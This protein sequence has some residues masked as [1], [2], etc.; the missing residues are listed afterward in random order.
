MSRRR[1]QGLS[2]SLFPFLAVLVCTLGTLILLLALV[3]Q[4]ATE[5]A[6]Q[7]ARAQSRV[8]EAKLKA[9]E[10]LPAIP[11]MTA[12]AAES[13]I[14]EQR[15][16]VEQLIAFRDKQT[17]DLEQRRDQLTHM[18]DH[19]ERLR[20]KL[21]RLS[22]EVDNAMGETSVPEIDD[23]IVAKLHASIDAERAAIEQIRSDSANKTP[24]VV[25]V[26]HK[27]PN[28]TDRRPVY[29]ECDAQGVTIWPEGSRITVAQLEDSTP[30]ANP[31]DAA[32]RAVRYHT[33]Q[34]YGDTTP[35][36]P[37]LV[38]RPD[39]IETYGAARKAMLDWDDQFGYELVPAEVKLAF[40]KP[41]SNL[42]QRVEIAI[43][44]AAARQYA[45]SAIVRR[46]T[47]GSGTGGSTHRSGGRMPTLSAA[48][49]D[50]AGRASGF[51]SAADDYRA[52]SS[53]LGRSPYTRSPP[54]TAG[55]RYASQND[56]YS[57]AG[58]YNG[59]YANMDPSASTRELADQMRNAAK[60]MREQQASSTGQSGL[61][62]DSSGGE[63]DAEN[64]RPWGSDQNKKAQD[65]TA[66]NGMAQAASN[67]N[68]GQSREELNGESSLTAEQS[69]GSQSDTQT[70]AAS[71]Q[72]HSLQA[73]SQ[74]GTSQQSASQ[75]AAGSGGPNPSG[76][77]SS[78][79]TTSQTDPHN[80][81]T[82]QQQT[83]A[84]PAQVS[85]NA[86]PRSDLVRRQGRDWALP[87]NMAG[88]RGNSIVRTI[89]VQC[90][91]DR[92]VL[93]PPSTGG[94]TEMFGFSDGDLDRATLELATAVRD[95]IDRWG[96][97]LPGGRWQPRLEVQVAPG[98][99]SR[100]HQLR[101][102][103][104]GSGVEVTGRASP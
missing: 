11:R 62:G 59:S 40:A 82:E 37:L 55:S 68:E 88:M 7:N 104:S 65:T 41:D 77:H 49:L 79:L 1:R 19:L 28:G 51:R 66:S 101:S 46:A 69:G 70:Q 83:A 85:L 102:L 21:K 24:R 61:G 74:S 3:A 18:E 42:K 14:S 4:N 91:S 71:P 38:V 63:Q 52:G 43:R 34:N 76:T 9:A 17:A 20:Q 36:Y 58:A 48:T 54:P 44:E 64:D 15:F 2:P 60:E 29:L 67:P 98:G 31:L 81:S 33:M 97:S 39:G 75:H 90:Y 6:E 50:R 56:A 5:T 95:R 84:V 27:G 80:R 30:S 57:S 87:P 93:L 10:A 45:R 35:P 53:Q 32:L 26:P 13:M 47:R 94:A 72:A 99:E 96:A 8:A 16:R 103:M 25:I 89:R 12:K 100:F 86:T 92:L 73:P 22:D 23:Q 78:A